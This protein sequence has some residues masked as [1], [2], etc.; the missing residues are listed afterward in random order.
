MFYCLERSLLEKS[1]TG[2]EEGDI[3][4]AES[5]T[6]RFDAEV[7]SRCEVAGEGQIKV[8]LTS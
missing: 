6:W 7:S 4:W 2:S 3:L 1:T 8:G 5:V